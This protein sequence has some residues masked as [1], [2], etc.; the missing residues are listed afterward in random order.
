MEK[1]YLINK[2]VSTK[3]D[4]E[5]MI[6]LAKNHIFHFFI[7]RD[8][9]IPLRG[10]RTSDEDN[11]IYLTWR[12][13]KTFY[14]GYCKRGQVWSLDLLVAFM[15]FMMTLV[16]IYLYAI[17]Y[18]SGSS[19][20]LNQL[21]LNADL[22]ANLLLSEDE[23]GLLSN[24][25]INKTKIEDFNSLPES[26]KR[27][28]FGASNNFYFTILDLGVVGISGNSVGIINTTEVD[29]QVKITRIVIFNDKPTK[30]EV[31]SWK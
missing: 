8:S 23:Y 24:G 29:T 22:V 25:E 19:E 20:D 2:R 11:A 31:I 5:R 1:F 21:F 15:I 17:S 6:F 12:Q 16:T 9:R 30:F 7:R 13:K 28:T 4:T 10:T 18:Y 14:R 27:S 3:K 26:L